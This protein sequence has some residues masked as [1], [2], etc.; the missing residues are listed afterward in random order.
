MS[1]F[2]SGAR[3]LPLGSSCSAGFFNIIANA[4]RMKLKASKPDAKSLEATVHFGF[5]ICRSAHPMAGQRRDN[6]APGIGRPQ[7][8]RRSCRVLA[9][10]F[11]LRVERWKSSVGSSRSTRP[12]LSLAPTRGDWYGCC[13]RQGGGVRARIKSPMGSCDHRRLRGA[14]PVYPVSFRRFNCNPG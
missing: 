8:L 2:F 11:S 10:N 5:R 14:Q 1:V 13:L 7:S 6:A 4:R 9:A 12:A 3:R